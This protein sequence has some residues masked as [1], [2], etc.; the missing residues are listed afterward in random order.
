[1]T[2]KY[3][4]RITA[5]A[6]SKGRIRYTRHLTEAAINALKAST[7][8]TDRLNS[9]LGVHLRCKCLLASDLRGIY[10][11]ALF[12]ERWFLKDR[13]RHPNRRYFFLTISDSNFLT[14]D[15][16]PIVSIEGFKRKI[17]NTMRNLKDLSAL[18]HFEMQAVCQYEGGARIII[19]HAHGIAWT[20]N[21]G[22]DPRATM[23]ALNKA[24]HWHSALGGRAIDILEI[25]NTEEDTRRTAHYLSK[26]IDSAKNRR[27][28]KNGRPHQTDTRK[29]YRADLALRMAEGLS[30]IP[31]ED[32]YLG[33]RGG[34]PVRRD[35]M[36]HLRRW[37]A[38]R[39][40]PAITPADFDIWEFWRRLRLTHGS[41][42]LLPWR[43][44]TQRPLCL[45]VGLYTLKALADGGAPADDTASTQPDAAAVKV[46]D[47]SDVVDVLDNGV[48]AQGDPAE[49]D[50]DRDEEDAEE[51]PRRRRRRRG[52]R[53][54]TSNMPTEASGQLET[55]DDDD[56]NEE[57]SKQRIRRRRK[58]RRRARNAH[59]EA[60]AEA[61]TEDADEDEEE[62]PAEQP[63]RRRRQRKS[64]QRTPVA[65]TGTEAK[66]EADE[67]E[68][69]ELA[70]QPRRRRR[71]KFQG[72]ARAIQPEAKAKTETEEDD[73]DEDVVKPP[74]RR[75]RKL[76]KDTR[77]TPLETKRARGGRG[78]SPRR[79]SGQRQR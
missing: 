50:A 30:L 17:N 1:M 72:S 73:D 18:V 77:G 51:Q 11:A 49:P 46:R 55:E 26:P 20:D 69:E 13:R 41:P 40:Q 42:R 16:S 67:G 22:F 14:D 3:S 57:L 78:T 58:S 74:R 31:V 64:Q 52:S 29:G 71:R 76:R 70:Q 36:T 12:I 59:I 37:H 9:F 28:R 60:G 8:D 33:I 45:P 65:P 54:G 68:G 43:V 27:R 75:R 39:P 56:G 25:A 10:K 34:S 35:L 6:R 62:E 32:T 23:A 63:R 66:T 53:D 24:G 7:E 2:K 5:R 38:Q 19:P 44:D 4:N 61:E 48:A 15:T 47:F 21:P 79:S